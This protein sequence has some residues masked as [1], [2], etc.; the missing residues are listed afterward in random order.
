MIDDRERIAVAS[1]IAVIVHAAL[2]VLID[3]LEFPEYTPSR[4]PLYVALEPMPPDVSADTPADEPTTPAEQPPAEVPPEPAPPPEPPQDA[5]VGGDRAAATPGADRSASAAEPAASSVDDGFVPDEPAA[6]SVEDGFVPDEPAPPSGPRGRIDRSGFERSEA[7]R[8][9]RFVSAQLDRIYTEQS[10]YFDE[11]AAYRD[12]QSDAAADA[13]D[14][15][16]SE[17]DS[18]AASPTD[19]E[20]L[21]SLAAA[22]SRMIAGIENADN[23]VSAVTDGEP[24][25]TDGDPDDSRE[26]PGDGPGSGTISLGDGAGART[27][28]YPEDPRIDLSGVELPAGFPPDYVVPVSFRVDA[29]GVVVDATADPR[30]PSQALISAVETQ[31]ETW[32][33]Q[34]A[35]GS[36]IVTGSITILVQTGNR[37]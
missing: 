6:S 35:P 5:A 14:S 13:M 4:P 21:N 15:D 29:A 2:F 24:G 7:P 12:R 34:S 16:G 26:S 10:D 28:V 19:S 18:E 30:V 37:R 1:L 31:I 33:F 11:L 20:R 25:A 22:L 17:P 32:R 23:V 8:D 9:P 36:R 27:L 3:R